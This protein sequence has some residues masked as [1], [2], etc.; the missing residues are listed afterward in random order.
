[1][2]HGAEDYSNVTKR[3]FSYRLDDMAEAVARLGSPL[4]YDRRGEVIFCD[5]FKY[6]LSGW[7]SLPSGL[8]GK[9]EI[10]VSHFIFD[11]ASAKL[12]AG[13]TQLH[14]SQIYRSFPLFSADSFGAETSFLVSNDV[15]L[16]GV[17]LQLYTGTSA[18]YAY[19]IYDYRNLRLRIYDHTWSVV[20][21]KT[22]LDTGKDNY[23]FSFMKLAVDWEHKK[24]LRALFNGE[25]F[26]LSE[27]GLYSIASSAVPSIQVI[28]MLSGDAGKNGVCYVDSFILTRNEI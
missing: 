24:Y 27:H 6:G 23:L 17:Y 7:R 20:V 22:G 21:L 19:L 4:I 28:L 18:Y 2:V 8:G 1:M 25:E 10:D 5:T 9:S 26:P 16:I 15:E 11:G 14:F 3:E 12:T 13:S